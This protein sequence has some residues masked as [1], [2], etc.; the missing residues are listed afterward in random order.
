MNYDL[1]YLPE[2]TAKPRQ[3]GMT[4]VMDKGLSTIEVENM[5]SVSGQYIDIVKLGWATSYVTPNLSEKL[6][7]YKAHNI[8]VYFG[9]TLFEC[10]IVRD[11]LADYKRALNKYGIAWVE[12]SDGSIEIP[13]DRKCEYIAELAKDFNVLS[14]VGSKD[15]EKIIAP[16]K[17]IAMMKNELA[18]GSKKVI[19]EAR[20]AGNEIGR[21][22]V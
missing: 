16:Y 14:E 7:V 1:L 5:L 21:A 3:S 19:A 17:W 8:P 9:G 10:F 2:R 4:M 11:Q 6:A 15:A 22:H 18:A 20:E 13:H 12:V